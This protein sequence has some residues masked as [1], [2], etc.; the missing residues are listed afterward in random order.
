MWHC[1]YS[2]VTSVFLTPCKMNST[3]YETVTD[4]WTD[5]KAF[6]R[7]LTIAL[8]MRYHRS[9]WRMWKMFVHY[10][11]INQSINQSIKTVSCQ[12]SQ[13]QVRLPWCQHHWVH[14]CEWRHPRVVE[15]RR[16]SWQLARHLLRGS[17]WPVC[18]TAGRRRF[19]PARQRS[20]RL[21]ERL[22][23]DHGTETTLQDV[24]DCPRSQADVTADCSSPLLHSNHF[25]RCQSSLW[26]T[27]TCRHI[28]TTHRF[29]ITV[30]MTHRHRHH[31][32]SWT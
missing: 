1:T 8:S 21:S 30:V 14:R 24:Q 29:I 18:R 32:C 6:R 20:R 13:Q 19:C 27:T 5:G 3:R 22:V 17:S 28:D 25:T 11:T 16:N 2:N 15:R 4:Q 12:L 23:L 10:Y 26:T 31:P 7:Q 9:N